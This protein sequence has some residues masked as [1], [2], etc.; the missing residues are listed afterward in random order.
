MS[1]RLRGGEVSNP[2]SARISEKRGDGSRAK[3]D[4]YATDPIAARLLLECEPLCKGTPIWEPA[5][6][7]GHLAEVFKDV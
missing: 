3:D 6:G 4:F 5:C 1:K 7:Q 2:L